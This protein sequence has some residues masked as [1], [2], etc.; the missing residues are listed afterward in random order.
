MRPKIE[1]FFTETFIK[2]MEVLVILN[3]AFEFKKL[4]Y[5]QQCIKIRLPLLNRHL[6]L[7]WLLELSFAL[8]Q[9][10]KSPNETKELFILA[11]T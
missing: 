11:L 4:S 5:K 9:L 8:L 7:P 6:H 2:L 10:R 1:I 3:I